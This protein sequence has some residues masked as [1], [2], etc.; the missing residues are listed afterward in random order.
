M[1]Y[2]EE[3]IRHQIE[4]FTAAS[5]EPKLSGAE[6]DEF[7]EQSRREGGRWDINGAVSLAW[8]RKA[9]RAV[10]ALADYCRRQSQRWRARVR[11]EVQ[12]ASAELPGGGAPRLQLGAGRDMLH[13][14]A[15]R[16]PRE[17]LGAPQSGAPGDG[18]CLPAREG[19]GPD[20]ADE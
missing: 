14:R 5:Q 17:A 10:G 9:E 20:E 19:G 3:Q 4:I 7:V 1:A 8:Q 16:Q 2:S 15:R 11:E 13:V 18:D 6:I 12:D